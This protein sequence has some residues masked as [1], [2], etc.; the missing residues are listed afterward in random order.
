MAKDRERACVYYLNEGN[1]IKGHAGTF[2]KACQKCK[3]YYAKKGSLPKRKDLR[4]EKNLKWM[5][6][7][8]NFE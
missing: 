8:K 7:I 1:C 2:K 5:N 3:D 4:K 6:N